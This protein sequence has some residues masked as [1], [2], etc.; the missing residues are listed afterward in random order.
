[1]PIRLD[2]TRAGR[3]T[4]RKAPPLSPEASIAAVAVGVV[5]AVTLMLLVQTPLRDWPPL[6]LVWFGLSVLPIVG[7]AQMTQLRRSQEEARRR[8][9]TAQ[10]AQLGGGDPSLGRY[11]VD[12]EAR[13]EE[14]IAQVRDLQQR[15]AVVEQARD[16][17]RLS[18]FRHRTEVFD[19]SVA[20]IR[21]HIDARRELLAQFE[22]YRHDLDAMVASNRAE[23]A[24][25]HVSPLS[26][27][28]ELGAVRRRLT[29]AI[30]ELGGLAEVDQA[31]RGL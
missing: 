9:E 7:A 15:L 21:S 1:M 3:S 28:E 13:M 25:E 14:L 17:V 27:H 2:N 10:L 8:A 24:L 11:V 12:C 30:D 22:I 4:K 16:K 18:S 5:T 31:L 6:L 19:R 26:A 29:E 20:L 23:A